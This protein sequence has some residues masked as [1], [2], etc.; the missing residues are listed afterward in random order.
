VEDCETPS[1]AP[2]AAVDFEAVVKL[3]A[4]VGDPT[5]TCSIAER[6]RALATGL[7]ELTGSDVFIWATGIANLAVGGEAAATSFIDGGWKDEKER[8]QVYHLVLTSEAS[9][10]ISSHITEDLRIGRARTILRQDVVPDERW[11]IMAADLRELGFG[12]VL[13][14]TYPL[15]ADGY[16]CLGL[17]RR[18]G[19]PPFTDRE[20]CLVH[21]AFQN[22]EWLHGEGLKTDAGRVALR[23]S[24]RQREVLLLLL[25]GDSQKKI[26]SK[27]EISLHT[28]A[29]Y[30][31]QIY[32]QFEVSSRGELLAQFISGGARL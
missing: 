3:L 25:K 28:V 24:P 13:Y 17:Q 16:S 32:R 26:A 12:E 21:V 29:D 15:G 10:T 4:E 6:K 18:V 31:K 1:L 19:K 7:A 22:V 2:L 30:M 8:A 27:L 5:T 9:L 14:T 20:R 23:L 11:P